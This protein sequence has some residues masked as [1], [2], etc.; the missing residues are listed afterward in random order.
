MNSPDLSVVVFNT[1]GH[2]VTLAW[3]CFICWNLVTVPT[4]DLQLHRTSMYVKTVCTTICE[5]EAVYQYHTRCY[6]RTD[7]RNCWKQ[8][9]V[10]ADDR[11][12]EFQTN[13]PKQR[14][15]LWPF[16]VFRKLI[17]LRYKFTLTNERRPPLSGWT[18]VSLYAIHFTATSVTDRT[19]LLHEM[20]VRW[21]WY[22]LL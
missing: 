12:Y 3:N 1:L 22:Y 8:V 18:M 7:C 14:G 21:S 17:T 5:T 20:V 10:R 15:C 16:F 6:S 11:L 9:T 2:E 19:G 13:C 4:V